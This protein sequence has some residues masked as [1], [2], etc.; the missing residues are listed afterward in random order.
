LGN[1]ES[2]CR[3][4]ERREEGRSSPLTIEASLVR[5]KSDRT[6]LSRSVPDPEK[7]E[8]TRPRVTLSHAHVALAS[9][10]LLQGPTILVVGSAIL[11][12]LVGRPGAAF[13][14]GPGSSPQC[15]SATTP[16]WGCC[17]SPVNVDDPSL[18]GSEGRWRRPGPV[19]H[20]RGGGKVSST[21]GGK[22]FLHRGQPR[23]RVVAGCGLDQ[24]RGW[25]RELRLGAE[26]ASFCRLRGVT[27]SR[28]LPAASSQA[29]SFGA[30]QASA[31]AAP[32]SSPASGSR[33]L[34]PGLQRL[35]D[36]RHVPVADCC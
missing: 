21:T 6:R 5:A 27:F 31:R 35:D 33:N 19:R 29:R 2:T 11:L 15:S 10:G 18:D 34:R 17:G 1:E 4:R 14:H 30:H 8:A 26:A 36:H 16:S 32:P 9:L 28:E 25:P 24:H 22:L 12:S 23:R 20:P 7:F 13:V 3:R